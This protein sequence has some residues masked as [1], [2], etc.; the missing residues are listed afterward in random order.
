MKSKKEEVKRDYSTQHWPVASRR[1][2][3]V[4]CF[5]LRVLCTAGFAGAFTSDKRTKERTDCLG[6][7]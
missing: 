2:R 5:V 6:L 3:F 4:L 1:L 7:R